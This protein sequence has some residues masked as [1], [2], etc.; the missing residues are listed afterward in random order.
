MVSGSS[1]KKK[2]KFIFCPFFT[3]YIYFVFNCS[4]TNYNTL[5]VKAEK[6]LYE[7]NDPL[8]ASRE[9]IPLV[10]KKNPDQL[11]FM[12][13]AGYMLHLAGD[14]Q[15]SNE[16]L[17]AADEKAEKM[18]KSVSKEV[19]AFI[20]NETGKDYMGEDYERILLN[21][22]IGINYLLLQD[23]E[24][25][26]VE[27][28]KVNSKLDFIKEKSG[29]SY[30]LN[31]MALYLSAVAHSA[32]G[33]YDY[34]Y[35]ELK[36]IHD[37]R[38]GIAFI[39][40]KLILLANELK[41]QD[42]LAIW[43]KKYPGNVNILRNKN[44]SEVI[45]V[46]EN[47][48]SP[49]K[50]S[51]GRLLADREV[52]NLFQA[53]VSVALATSRSSS[54]AVSNAVVM[55]TVE[56]AEHPIPKYVLQKYDIA[57]A[58]VEL[59]QNGVKAATIETLTL[60]DVEDTMVSNFEEHYLKIREKMLTRLAAKVVATLVSKEI[61]EQS[62]RNAGG[63]YGG[64]ASL[65]IGT[66]VGIGTGAVLFSTEKPDLRCWHSIPANYQSGSAMLPEGKYD[67]KIIYYDYDGN[68]VM[69]KNHGEINLREGA[70]SIINFRAYN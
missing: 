38:P 10:N 5:M 63:R 21:M 48:K 8:N 64:I 47:G 36:K 66:M 51:R 44:M 4:S 25:A 9:L 3:F 49:R 57:F 68:F 54:R 17:M 16:V 29:K 37:I 42:D 31:L 19:A 26:Q 40:Q 1:M 35:I 69:E 32:T 45:A 23:Y 20:T 41:Y 22:T 39:G 13:E 60:N 52:Y 15:K 58:D 67:V 12:M 33:E 2:L 56:T 7:E 30:N 27:F 65:L 59:S 28:K 50:E 6:K 43:K 14:F 34:A 55:Q 61:A 24:S 18:Y 70:P 62:A 53:A 46:F 11:L